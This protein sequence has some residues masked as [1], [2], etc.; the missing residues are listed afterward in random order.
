VGLGRQGRADADRAGACLCGAA[1]G[2]PRS[3]ARRAVRLG[4]FGSSVDIVPQAIREL[5][6]LPAS[7]HE[8]VVAEPIL[9]ALRHALVKKAGRTPAEQEFIVTMHNTWEQARDEGRKEGRD[10][11]R[12]VQAR[13]AVRRVLARRALAPSGAEESRI[14]TCT[15]IATLEQWLDQALVA[16]SVAEALQGGTTSRSSRR[17]S[18]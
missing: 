8:R 7:A 17:R 12:L 6:A 14:D 16:H 13:A 9:L 1:G 18:S 3:A 2:D 4:E 10:E 5:A 15:D 11:G